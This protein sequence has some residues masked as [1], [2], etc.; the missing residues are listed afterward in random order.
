MT[1]DGVCMC[2]LIVIYDLVTNYITKL[3]TIV[4]L[5]KKSDGNFLDSYLL[6]EL[7]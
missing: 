7:N 1:S 3:L 5:S 2:F 4:S 6:A